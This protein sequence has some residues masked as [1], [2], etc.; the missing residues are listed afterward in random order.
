[1]Q[2]RI[3]SGK[4][5]TTREEY[6]AIK[7]LDRGDMVKFLQGIYEAGV[8]DGK[9]EIPEEMHVRKGMDIAADAVVKSLEETK[10]IGEKRREEVIRRF[11]EYSQEGFER[12]KA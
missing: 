10:G 5:E 8:E 1:M 6:K 3:K 11:R 7:R 4:V 12:A 9:P 2:V